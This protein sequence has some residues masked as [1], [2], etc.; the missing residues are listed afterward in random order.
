MLRKQW[1]PICSLLIGTAALVAIPSGAWARKLHTYYSFAGGAHGE[2]PSG[3]IVDA[4]G[5]LYGTTLSG[6]GDCNCGT[7]FKVAPDGAET[8]LYSFRGLEDGGF[9]QASLIRD[10]AGNLYGTTSGTRASHGTVFRLRPNGHLRTLHNFTKSGDGSDPSSSLVMD[11]A[12]NLYGTTLGGGASDH[13]TVYRIAPDQTETV[14]Y[15]FN[16]GTDGSAPGSALVLDHAGNLYG[17]TIYGGYLENDYCG[18]GGCGTVFRIAPD[19]TETVLY[20]FLGDRDGLFPLGSV[21]LDPQDNLYGMTQNG[22]V[23]GDGAIFKLTPDGTKT[24]LYSLALGTGGIPQSGLIRDR[25]GNLYGTAQGGSYS[26]G[27]AFEFTARGTYKILHDFTDGTDGRYLS[28][29]LTLDAGGNV[30][31]ATSQGG[32][33]GCQSNGCGTVFGIE[34]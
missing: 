26:A 16:G 1:R 10:R 2:S 31:G 12:S 15:S 8:I 19:G 17:T 7:V 21:A 18:T 30:Y 32:D 3:V 20:A 14:I 13:G 33:F 9:P 6:G 27:V 29:N 11:H 4:N 34:R 24:E 23:Y 5:N 25:H 22:G 28:G